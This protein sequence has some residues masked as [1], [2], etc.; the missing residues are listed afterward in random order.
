MPVFSMTKRKITVRSCQKLKEVIHIGIANTMGQ[1]WAILIVYQLQSN[2]P[3]SLWRVLIVCALL[4]SH[5]QPPLVTS[6]IGLLNSLTLPLSNCSEPNITPTPYLS[7]IPLFGITDGFNSSGT[8]FMSTLD[9]S[10][11]KNTLTLSIATKPLFLNIHNT[12]IL[13]GT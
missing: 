1:I 5:S 8:Y 12:L 7:Y 3:W 9:P 2:T 11:S 13:W 6:P 4:G 10:N